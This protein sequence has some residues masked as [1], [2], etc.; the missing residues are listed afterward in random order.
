MTIKKIVFSSLSIYIFFFLIN[1]IWAQENNELTDISNANELYHEKDYVAAAKIF[2]NL[3]TE[4]YVNGYLYYNL[5]NTHMRLGQIGPAILNYLRA[6]SLLP[7]NESIEANLKYAINKTVDRLDPPRRGFIQELF[8][9]IEA[10]S[11]SEYFQ[12]LI[13]FN[14]LFWA[15]S[16][17]FFCLRT[18]AW[19]TLKTISMMAFLIIFISTGIKYSLQST[20]KL[21]VIMDK[22][23]EVKSDTG[24]QNIT[25][26]ELNEGAIIKVNEENGNWVNISL[27]TDESG[28]VPIRSIGYY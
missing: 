18:P 9:W 24:L 7:R 14:M 12:L 4:G 19:K 17:G 16:I 8:F 15:L 13:L 21:G 6:K 25:L 26:F 2:N 22:K 3:I 10:A 20:Q 28:W 23:I 11:L 5:G 1:S 27:D